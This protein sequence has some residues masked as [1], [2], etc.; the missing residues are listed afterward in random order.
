MPK[1]R[2]TAVL[3][4]VSLSATP[5]AED[6]PLFGQLPNEAGWKETFLLMVKVGWWANT[7]AAASLLCLESVSL[8]TIRI[9]ISRRRLLLLRDA[10]ERVHLALDDESEAHRIYMQRGTLEWDIAIDTRLRSRWLRRIEIIKTLECVEM[11]SACGGHETAYVVSFF[12]RT[13]V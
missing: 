12:S 5:L 10:Y 4:R 11:F 2:A 13:R 6:A 8:I 9:S 1:G 7:R 3:H